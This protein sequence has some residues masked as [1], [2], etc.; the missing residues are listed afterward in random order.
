MIT[1]VTAWYT[2]NNKFDISHYQIWINNFLANANCNI[3]IFTNETSKSILNQYL[4]KSNIHIIIK[5]LS[6]FFTYKYSSNWIK[7][8]LLSEN[9]L[10][11][12]ISWQVNMLWNEKIN[13]VKH[14]A[15]INIFNTEIFAWC[16][17]G[18]FRCRPDL[19]INIDSIKKWPNNSTINSL[20]KD[21]I[22]Y[23][24][25]NSLC[26]RCSNTKSLPCCN[27]GF[28]NKIARMV[29]TKNTFDLPEIPIP[30]RQVTI[31]GGF[32]V[33]HKKKIDFWHKLFYDRL[34]LYF[35]HNYL[36]KD[37]QIV[38]IDCIINNQSHFKLIEQKNYKM[39][40][41]FTFSTF[42]L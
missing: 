8:L 2:L 39:D 23:N 18:Y 25:A 12:Q 42:L 20:N 29:K 1:I 14:A 30:P 31:S 28:T 34:D 36:V 35:T 13:F 41:W 6:D 10:K 7:D 19:D 24:M 9:P 22:Y 15:D 38:L 5:E 26:P 21:K 3:I 4:T 16:D 27:N 37:D 32:F 40:R 17:I 11:G 33:I